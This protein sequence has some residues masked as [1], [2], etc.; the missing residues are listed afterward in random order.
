MDCSNG[1]RGFLSGQ[2]MPAHGESLYPLLL[3][4]AFH[5]D[6]ADV[7]ITSPA[8]VILSGWHPGRV[9]GVVRRAYDRGFLE[10]GGKQRPPSVFARWSN[11][12]RLT[13][14][15]RQRRSSCTTVATFSVLM[16]MA[17]CVS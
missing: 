11:L 17:A 4:L 2:P 14:L 10:Y 1:G 13:T 12:H 6:Y 5:E 7:G 9:A 8:L 16:P 3:L 15:G